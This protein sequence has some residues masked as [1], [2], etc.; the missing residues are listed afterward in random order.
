MSNPGGWAVAA[1]IAGGT[2]LTWGFNKAYDSNFLG[3]QDGLDYVGEKVDEFTSN[4]HE[5]I[6]NVTESASNFV[7]D[8]G[9]A[10]SGTLD[11]INPFS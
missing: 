1:G 6:S 2:L 4:V 7:E 11:A 5:T 10:I 9:E 3:I 8:V